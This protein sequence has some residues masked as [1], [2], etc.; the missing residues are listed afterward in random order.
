MVSLSSFS[1]FPQPDRFAAPA[2]AESSEDRALLD[3][4]DLMAE[5]DFQDRWQAAKR[6]PSFGQAGLNGL[7]DLLQYDDD[8]ELHWFAARIL[9]E[10]DTP[11]AVNY[12]IALVDDDATDAEVKAV[13]AQTLAQLG[14]PAIEP[15]TALLHEP[16]WRLLAVR[17]L[18]SLNL[19]QAIDPLFEL[20]DDASPEVRAE[21]LSVLSAYNDPRVLSP[22]VRGLEDVAPAV[23]RQATVGLGLRY[24]LDRDGG[25]V[26]L[27]ERRLLDF[28]LGVCQQAALSL[29]RVGTPA[30]VAVL[31][32]TLRSPHTPLPLQLDIV[33]A[34][35]WIDRREAIDLLADALTLPSAEVCREALRTLGRICDR[36]L[37]PQAGQHLVAWCAQPSPHREQPQIRQALALA[38]GS[39][40]PD[41]GEAILRSL[42][43]DPDK[44]VRWHAQAGYRRLPETF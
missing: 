5:G 37:Q 14:Q 12:L 43:D 7:L 24:A 22:L 40:Q 23:R 25:F 44:T 11:E 41:G 18:A 32:R 2:P 30:A 13:A 4:L 17:A 36:H 35:G 10:F 38:L 21:I 20:S 6:L 3:T 42:L 8:D 31:G 34:L 9:G 16:R 1:A 26:E 29:S 19:P 39:L 27:L 28:D 15:L 33:R